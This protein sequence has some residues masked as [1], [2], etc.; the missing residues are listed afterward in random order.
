[1]G[2]YIFSDID[3]VRSL[4]A[5][6]RNLFQKVYD[7]IKHL[8][9]LATAGSKEARELE[10]VKKLFAD[11]YREAGAEKSTAKDGGVRYSLAKI[12]NITPSNEQKSRTLTLLP[13]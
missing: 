10:K 3:F 11:V 9:K 6:D 7:E 2:D 13:I 12:E 1:V 5:G 4:K 8:A